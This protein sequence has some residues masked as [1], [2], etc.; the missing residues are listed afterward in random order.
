MAQ[1]NFSNK[2]LLSDSSDR[3]KNYLDSI[4]RLIAQNGRI[5]DLLIANFI[6]E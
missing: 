3:N 2:N 5:N 6:Q 1:F 4:D